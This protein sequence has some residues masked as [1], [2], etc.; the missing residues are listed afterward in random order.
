LSDSPFVTPASRGLSSSSGARQRRALQ[1]SLFLLILL[2]L[3]VWGQVPWGSFQF[4]D[5]TNIV[6]DPATTNAAS[7]IER[8]FH[9]LRPLTR[10]SYFLDAKLFGLNPAAFLTT[11]L[12]LHLISVLLVFALVFTRAGAAGAFLA[13][14]IFSLQPAN[15]EVIA[16]ASG[17]S[18]GLMT[19]L[20][21]GGLVCHDRARHRIAFLFFALACLAKEVALIFPALVLVWDLAQNKPAPSLRRMMIFAGLFMLLCLMIFSLAN[22]RALI[23]YSLALRPFAAN[24]LANARAVPVMLS[25]WF[26]PWALS[27]DH[28]FDPNN[29][30]LASIAALILILGAAATAF[31]LRQRYP[32]LFLFLVWPLIALLPTNSIIAKL[33]P[34]TE[35]PLYLAWIGPSIAIGITLSRWIAEPRIRK[36]ALTM[37]VV[38]ICF[39]AATSMQRA[40]LWR[41]PVLLW[42]DA[43]NK[44]PNKSRCWNNLGMAYLNAKRDR[45]AVAAFENAIRLDPQNDF[46]IGN[47]QLALMLCGNDCSDR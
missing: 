23:S 31:R 13:A 35:K 7:L 24:V 20:L 32:Q 40:S 34:V 10:I 41:D 39:L 8:L 37:C 5:F 4:D 1:T 25:L 26:R 29:H 18:T 30:V 46:A 9:G 33:D 2:T 47:L 12:I 3:I 28:D 43:T 19:L 11:N 36:F 22:Y 45:G 21:L 15:A 27:P 44:A 16:Y 42:Q 17:R 38:L 6:R 14:A